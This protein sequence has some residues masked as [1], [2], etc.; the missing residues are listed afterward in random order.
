[1]W[2]L[3]VYANNEEASIPG[4]VLKKIKEEIDGRV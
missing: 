3:T 2:L 1:M 4:Y